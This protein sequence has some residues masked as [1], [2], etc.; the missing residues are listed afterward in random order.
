VGYLF[1]AEY[2]FSGHPFSTENNAGASL[3][4]NDV[5]CV[6][7]YA[8][9]RSA[10][11]MMPATINCTEGWV[12]E[13]GGYIVS[14]FHN[15]NRG[16]YI[17]LDEAPEVVTGGLSNTNGALLYPVI[18]ACGAVPCPK[19]VNGRMLSCVVCSLLNEIAQIGVGL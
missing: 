16:E 2:E 5:P 10:Q 3:L 18:L 4:E 6:V 13:Y 8:P 17:C 1:G 19:Y 9:T 12:K 7:C 11:L 14:E 15:H